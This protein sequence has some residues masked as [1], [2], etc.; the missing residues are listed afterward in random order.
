MLVL[1]IL[2]F[3][4]QTCNNFARQAGQNKKYIHIERRGMEKQYQAADIYKTIKRDRNNRAKIVE[5]NGGFVEANEITRNPRSEIHSGGLGVC[6]RL[7]V[8]IRRTDCSGF[9]KRVSLSVY[10]AEKG[11]L[12]GLY[13]WVS[14]PTDPFGRRS[15][16][17]K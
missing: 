1:Y 16:Y 11:M 17:L 10:A 3:D 2:N 8:Y 6:D 9:R 12:G 4:H 14:R 13:L 5:E 7:S 15:R